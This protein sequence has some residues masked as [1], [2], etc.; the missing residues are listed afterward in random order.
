MNKE[1]LST[2]F[3]LQGVAEQFE[4]FFEFLESLVRLV[5]VVKLRLE[6][7]AAHLDAFTE[8]GFGSVKEDVEVHVAAVFT[9]KFPL[10][11]V[12]RVIRNAAQ[13]PTKS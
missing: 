12:F 9:K 7:K 8:A 13:V 3:G 10:L 5:A 11:G 6:A 1:L 2:N 4:L